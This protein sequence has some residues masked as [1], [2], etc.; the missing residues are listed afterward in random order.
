VRIESRPG[1]WETVGEID[2]YGPIA[3]DRHLVAFDAPA[4]WTGR[5]ELRLTKGGWRI[6]D[7]SLARLG[8]PVEPL[9]LAP[10]DVAKDGASD[11]A[12]RDALRDRARAL[13]TLPG[14]VY[15]LLFEIPDDGRE[16]QL[17]IESR[18]YYLEW[19]REQWLREESAA[20]LAQMF[21]DPRAALTRLAPEYKRIEPTMEQ[22]FWSSRYETP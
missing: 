2:E 19:I 12:A 22:A 6:D 21:F 4:E 3:V 8:R 20:H 11:P 7:V 9:R 16:Y 1:V 18:G 5:A 17:F 13:T 15:T 14:D 10:A